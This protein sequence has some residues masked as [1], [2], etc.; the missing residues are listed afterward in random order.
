MM[1]PDDSGFLN[2]LAD[3]P[4]PCPGHRGSWQT[5]AHFVAVVL[6]GTRGG[7]SWPSRTYLRG[8][9][10]STGQYPKLRNYPTEGDIVLHPLRQFQASQGVLI[11]TMGV[12]P[13][14]AENPWYE[15]L[16]RY[17]E[18][19]HPVR[20]FLSSAARLYW[21]ESPWDLPP[22]GVDGYWAV[23]MSPLVT[24]V[25]SFAVLHA[26]AVLRDADGDGEPEQLGHMW[27]AGAYRRQGVAR[28][29]LERLIQTDG[30]VCV[31]ELQGP[32][33]E[34]GVKLVQ[35]VC[36]ELPVVIDPDDHPDIEAIR[37]GDDSAERAVLLSV[38][39]GA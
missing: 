32:F 5:R 10:V 25:G 4:P 11:P 35:A 29:F 3:S 38:G 33:T 21:L 23:R 12:E 20:A 27:V 6:R 8:E 14:S 9:R 19:P 1:S 22:D 7:H 30:P 17:A 2:S 13:P 34:A 26:F 28:E 18:L 36:P 31:R 16:G 39:V 15:Y 37:R 24:D